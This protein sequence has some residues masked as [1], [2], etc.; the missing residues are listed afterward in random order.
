[1]KKIVTL[2]LITCLIAGMFGA[3]AF[4]QEEKVTIRVLTRYT[5]TDATTPVFQE[6]IRTFMEKNP[7]ITIQDDSVNEE[8]A[9]NNKLMTA[10][11]TGDIPNIFYLPGLMSGVEYA[12]NGVIMDVSELMEDKAWYDGFNQGSFEPWNFTPFG[13][14]GYFGVPFSLGVEVFFYNKELFTKAGI[15]KTPETLAEFYEDVEKLKAIGVSPMAI[16]AKET[17]RA[18]HVLNWLFFK[19]VGIDKAK[20]IG[21]RTAKWTD[22]DVVE[23]LKLYMDLKDRGTFPVNYEGVSYD[24]EKNMFFSEQA[25]MVLNGS[26]FVGDCVASTIAD[27]IGVFALPYIEGKEQFKGDSIIYPQGFCLSG[28]ATGAERDAQILFIKYMT[29]FDMQSKMVETV[30]RMS[31]RS[32]IDFTQIALSPIFTEVDRISRSISNSGGDTFDFD[33]LQS[34][35]DRTRNSLVGMSLGMS[36]EEAAE[37]IQSEIDKNS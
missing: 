24:E 17:W 33:P 28:K 18:G 14:D 21:A 35:C 4:A 29:N 16:G 15:E 36:P 3:T 27:K 26:W 23:T 22:S 30:Q 25:A 6:M 7:N 1:M 37:E 19:N 34:M 8:A 9:Y 20:A 2:L 5:G 12:K 11:A 10:I 32:D 13:V 31:A